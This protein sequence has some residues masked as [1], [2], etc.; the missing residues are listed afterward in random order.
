MRIGDLDSAI[1]ILEN[2]DGY[3]DVESAGLKGALLLLL[4]P[5]AAGRPRLLQLQEL[6]VQQEVDGQRAAALVEESLNER[7][8]SAAVDVGTVFHCWRQVP[9]RRRRRL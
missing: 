4:R 9:G 7:W 8:G 1:S 3:Y 2:F 6:L 5:P